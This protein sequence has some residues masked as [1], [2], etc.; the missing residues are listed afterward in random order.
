MKILRPLIPTIYCLA[1]LNNYNLSLYLMR[2]KNHL[3]F[4]KLKT[5]FSWVW[6]AKII[7]KHTHIVYHLNLNI[8]R[9]SILIWIVIIIFLVDFF[10]NAIIILQTNLW[11]SRL[12]TTMFDPNI[13]LFRWWNKISLCSCLINWFWISIGHV[14][15]DVP[16]NRFVEKNRL[17]ADHSKSPKSVIGRNNRLGWC[18]FE[19]TVQILVDSVWK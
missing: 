9:R 10:I 12:N 3:N 18:S 6:K 17:L 19:W 4:S 13:W 2:N 5:A 8:T 14:V 11:F 1:Q 16:L 15:P 7:I